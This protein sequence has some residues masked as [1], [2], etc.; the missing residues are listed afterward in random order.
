ME[1]LKFAFLHFIRQKPA[2]PQMQMF[3]FQS[4]PVVA[5][6]G[7]LGSFLELREVAKVT[8]RMKIFPGVGK[9]LSKAPDRS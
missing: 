6:D 7:G 2:K 4:Q 5:V 1:I 9:G 3:I 8:Q